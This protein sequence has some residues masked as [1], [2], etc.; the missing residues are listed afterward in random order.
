[1]VG[2][3]KIED[4]NLVFELHVIDEILSINSPEHTPFEKLCR[5]FR[6]GKGTDRRAPMPQIFLKFTSKLLF[7]YF[8][9]CLD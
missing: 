2:E 8:D 4:G 5:W 6:V 7:I 1:M 3:V 9:K